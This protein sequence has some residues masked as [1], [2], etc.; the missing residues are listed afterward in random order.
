M[1]LETIELKLEN[2]RYLSLQQFLDDCKLIFSNCRTYNPDGS[3]YVKNA[4]RLE[5]FL[6]DRVKQYDEIEY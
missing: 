6:K 1:D 4:N 2:N 3:N 5:K